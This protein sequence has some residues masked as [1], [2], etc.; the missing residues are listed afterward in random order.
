M[1]TASNEIGQSNKIELLCWILGDDA[2]CIFP[3]EIENG[4][5]V[6]HLK[7]MIKNKNTDALRDVD[8]KVLTLW[9]VGDSTIACT[10]L[11]DDCHDFMQCRL[12]ISI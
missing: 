6:G 2:N 9:K 8:A 3:V 12:M 11:F 7:D 5:T 1:A 4:K 10:T